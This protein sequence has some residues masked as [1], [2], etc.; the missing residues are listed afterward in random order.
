MNVAEIVVTGASGFV[1]GHVIRRA[2]HRGL[3][4]VALSRSAAVVDPES[5]GVRA[6]QVE[7]YADY[8]PAPGSVLIHL[9]EPAQIPAVDQLGQR[10]IDDMTRQARELLARPYTRAIYASSATIYGDQ[11][12][13]PHQPAEQPRGGHKVYA[14]AKIQVE[15]LFIEAGGVVAR[16]TNVYGAG[17]AS[18]NIFSD[19]VSQLSGSGPLV[20]REE[21]PIREYLWVDDVADGLLAMACGS[22]R[23]FFNLSSGSPISCIGLARL[24]LGLSGQADRAVHALYP[25]RPSTLLLDITRTTTSFG[26][27]PRLSIEDGIKELLSHYGY[28]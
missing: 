4:V 19:I 16:L 6:V 12:A 18:T 8:C 3:P 23:G 2:V 17:M 5:T 28:H 27:T 21:T 20:I 13:A 25:P 7:R 1:A 22:D 10:H 24:I 15:K 26:W 9:G 14:D 11:E